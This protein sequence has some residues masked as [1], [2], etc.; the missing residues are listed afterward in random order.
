MQGP[1]NRPSAT[2]RGSIVTRSLNPLPSRTMISLRV[3]STSFELDI[4]HA[5]TQS[6]QHAQ[7]AAIKQ[8]VAAC[9]GEKYNRSIHPNPHSPLMANLMSAGIT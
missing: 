5:Q 1:K 6:L 3:N 8:A 4:F 7:A 2:A 9:I